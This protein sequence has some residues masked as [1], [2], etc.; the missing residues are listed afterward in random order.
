MTA[1]YNGGDIGHKCAVINTSADSRGLYWL[2]PQSQVQMACSISWNERL[3]TRTA[4]GW[5]GE[6]K[7]SALLGIWMLWLASS[8]LRTHFWKSTLSAPSGGKPVR[9]EHLLYRGTCSCVLSLILVFDSLACFWLA[10]IP[11]PTLT[12]ECF[13]MGATGASY[14]HWPTRGGKKF[15]QK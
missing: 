8:V 10:W 4:N 6:S 13:I 15:V 1:F 3:S 9:D 5:G 11:N 7:K 12:A 2:A 14:F